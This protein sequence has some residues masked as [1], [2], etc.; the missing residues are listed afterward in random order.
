MTKDEAVKEILARLEK[1]GYKACEYVPSS[2][3]RLFQ[4]DVEAEPN[5]YQEAIDLCKESNVLMIW[6]EHPSD[7]VLYWKLKSARVTTFRQ[8]QLD[9]IME[10]ARD[11]LYLKLLKDL[12]DWR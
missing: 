2:Q 7:K 12:G 9:Y 11:E 3:A 10:V 6:P 4:I 8:L 1:S 5:T